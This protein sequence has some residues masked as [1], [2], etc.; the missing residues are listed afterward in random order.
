[1]LHF[2]LSSRHV[3]FGTCRMD[4]TKLDVESIH[5]LYEIK[6]SDEEIS[7]ITTYLDDHPGGIHC[8]AV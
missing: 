4:F 3:L 7:R 5:G 8:S 6:G 1:M 2:T